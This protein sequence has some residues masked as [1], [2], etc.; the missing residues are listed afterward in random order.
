[1]ATSP[2]FKKRKTWEKEEMATAIAAVREKRMGYLKAA[3]QFN[4]PRATLFRF[5]NDKDS[6]IESIINK[7][8]GRR[9]VW[10]KY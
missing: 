4:V 7:V 9:P 3:K 8:I 5:V 1:M 10:S 2:K 6:P